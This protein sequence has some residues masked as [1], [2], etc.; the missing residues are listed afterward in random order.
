MAI[1]EVKGSVYA[2]FTS[3]RDTPYLTKPLILSPLDLVLTVVLPEEYRTVQ[4]AKGAKVLGASVEFS[5]SDR[6]TRHY[7][8]GIVKESGVPVC[9]RVCAVRREGLSLLATAISDAGGAFHL[10]WMGYAGK[11]VILIFDDATD[12]LDYNC[13]VFDL[14]ESVY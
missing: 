14:V 9:R 11:V 2:P 7:A 3:V 8:Q 10:E 13:K 5:A 4:Y 6:R 12:A 1:L